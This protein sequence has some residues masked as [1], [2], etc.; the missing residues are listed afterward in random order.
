MRR[1]RRRT[2]RT[3]ARRRRR[4]RWRK[5]TRTRAGGEEEEDDDDGEGESENEDKK[6]YTTTRCIRHLKHK[7]EDLNMDPRT[8]LKP[9]WSWVTV[10][11]IFCY[12]VRN[13]EKRI[14]RHSLD[15]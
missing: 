7:H 4:R 9:V 11:L 13:A 8:H 5:R 6:L 3:R 10:I 15:S 1:R 12:K 2:T 14:T